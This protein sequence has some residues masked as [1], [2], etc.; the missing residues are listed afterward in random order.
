M[1]GTLN[2]CVQLKASGKDLF[3]LTCRTLGLR[4]TWYFGLQYVD[5][6]G[7]IR[8]LRHDKRVSNLCIDSFSCKCLP[9]NSCN[10]FFTASVDVSLA[11]IVGCLLLFPSHLLHSV[12]DEKCL[13]WTI[14]LGKMYVPYYLIYVLG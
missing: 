11:C 7:D 10:Y 3:E 1:L 12:L 5:S 6:K 14:L 8:W 13:Y 9:I 2:C 4:E